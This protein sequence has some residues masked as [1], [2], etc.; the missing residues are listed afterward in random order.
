[1]TTE[2]FGERAVRG[3]SRN[4]RFPPR[5][6]ARARELGA[7]AEREGW[8]LD[9]SSALIGSC[10]NSSYEDMAKCAALTRQDVGGTL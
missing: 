6:I 4:P 1:M 8:P 5:E 3:D 10:T 7:R 9:I 2:R